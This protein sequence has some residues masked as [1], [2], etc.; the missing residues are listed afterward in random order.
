MNMRAQQFLLE[1]ADLI[2]RH[3]GAD[4]F[5]TTADDGVHIQLDG[6]QDDC[7]VGFD[8]TPRKLRAAAA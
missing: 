5:Y 6:D 7:F 8:L 2:E 1:L 3:G 4:F